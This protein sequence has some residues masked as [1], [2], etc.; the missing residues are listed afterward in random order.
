MK[1]LQPW[2]KADRLSSIDLDMLG[3][4]KLDT[5]LV[6]MDNTLVPWHTFD[7]DDATE[8]WIAQAKTLGFKICVISNNKKWRITKMMGMLHVQGVWNACKPFIGGYIRALRAV[9]SHGS[10][11]VFIGDQIFTDLLGA[12]L[13]GIKTILVKPISEREYKWTQFMRRLERLIA[14]RSPDKE[15]QEHGK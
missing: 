4:E 8:R 10:T 5:L 12:N 15:A 1:L 3:R 7:V 6:D 11:T 9:K 13:L 2:L 14:S